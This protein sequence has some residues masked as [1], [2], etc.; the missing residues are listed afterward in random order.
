MISDSKASLMAQPF[1]YPTD[2]S[3]VETPG[4][5]TNDFQLSRGERWDAIDAACAA[6]IAEQQGRPRPWFPVRAG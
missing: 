4:Y 3:W 5:S 2:F 1:R 6:I